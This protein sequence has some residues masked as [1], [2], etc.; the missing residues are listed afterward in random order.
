MSSTAD[1]VN[2]RK[3]TYTFFGAIAYIL[4]ALFIGSVS[5]PEVKLIH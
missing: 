3:S 4:A 1:A 2:K 5:G